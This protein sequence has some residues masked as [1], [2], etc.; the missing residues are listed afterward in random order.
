[1]LAGHEKPV[2]AVLAMKDRSQIEEGGLGTK[3]DHAVLK[4]EGKG[5]NTILAARTAFHRAGGPTGVVQTYN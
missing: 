3:L 5:K 4:G 1:V 2:C